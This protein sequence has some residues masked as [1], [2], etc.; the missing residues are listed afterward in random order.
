MLIEGNFVFHFETVCRGERQVIS[1][2]IPTGYG[3]DGRYSI[4]LKSK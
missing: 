3:L 1:V 2:R 4:P